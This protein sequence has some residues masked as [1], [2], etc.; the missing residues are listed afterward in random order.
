MVL[1]TS[2]TGL[3]P[4]GT[5]LHTGDCG[6]QNFLRCTTSALASRIDAFLSTTFC[7]IIFML[8]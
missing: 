1:G 5:L 4:M 3:F 7:S 2:A 6:M 8:C